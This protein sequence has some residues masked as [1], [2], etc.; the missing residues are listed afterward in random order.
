MRHGR[1][2]YDEPDPDYNVRKVSL[3]PDEPTLDSALIE[4]VIVCVCRAPTRGRDISRA[5]LDLQSE[6]HERREQPTV[7]MTVF[8]TQIEAVWPNIYG[9]LDGIRKMKALT[10]ST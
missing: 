6:E 9:E 3:H 7:C 8:V 1:P 4:D 2:R 10:K 5:S